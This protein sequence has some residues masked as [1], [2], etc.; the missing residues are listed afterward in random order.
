MINMAKKCP[1]S[2]SFL[3]G[4]L[5]FFYSSLV[6]A[7]VQPVAKPDGYAG[8]RGTTGGGNARP[9]TVST[10]ADFRS[11]VGN[12]NP[13]VIIVNGRLNVGNVSIGSNKTIVGATTSSGLYGGTIRVGGTNYIF[14]NLT[15]GPSDGDGIEV[16]GAT[17]VFITNCEFYDGADG[18]LD[19]VRGADYVTVSWCKFYYVSQSEHRFSML[20]GNGDDVTSDDGKLHVTLHH[21]WFAGRVDQRMPRVRYGHIHIYNNYYNST[22][23]G[24]CIGTGYKCRIRLE[25]SYFESVNH[26]WRDMG[27]TTS[28]GRM[29]WSNLRFVSSSQPSYIS[30]SYPVFTVPYQYEADPVDDVKNKVRSC[31]GNVVCAVRDCNGDING[32][33]YL[34]DCNECVG[35]RTGKTACKVD[36]NGVK[37]GTA[38]SDACGICIGGNT[39]RTACLASMQGEDFCEAEGFLESKNAGFTGAGYINFDNISGAGGR[40]N[41]YATSSMTAVI[42]VRYANGGTEARGMSV[43]VNGIEQ[44]SIKGSLT[45]GWTTWATENITLNLRP[46]VNVLELKAVSSDGPNIDL[47]ALYQSGLTS[48]GCVE[49]CNGVTGGGAYTDQCGVCVGGTT[50]K[51][52]CEQDCAGT[53]GGDAEEDAC[54]VCLGSNEAYQACSGSLEAEEACEVDGILPEDRNGG[55]SGAGYVNTTNALGSYVTWFLESDKT[56]RI[57]LSFRYANAGVVSRDGRVILNGADAGLLALPSTGSWSEWKLATTLLELKEGINELTLVSATEEGL[58]NLDILYFSGGVSNGDCMI[59]GISGTLPDQIISVYPNPTTGMVRWEVDKKWVL[60]SAQGKILNQGLG[61]SA[62]LSEYSSGLYMLK[63]DDH[64][65]QIIRK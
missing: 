42:G 28:G 24:Y 54:G 64:F 2:G 47:F 40:W 59:T 65:I 43:L 31:A 6:P 18:N 5:I 63:L 41:L 52:A 1:Y 30:N 45:G 44:A 33:A 60:L 39:G 9:V 15:I 32:D 11:A 38:V 17:N 20:I 61:N 29:G 57:A 13:A 14:Q 27:A 22:G 7:Q 3:I 49:D 23:N 53:W 51:T 46:G 50:G 4:M 8:W 26:P 19:I 25:N 62:D 55:F 56:Q 10:A 37:N 12:N 48:G 21:N 58:A 34:D 35:G 16:S 36:C